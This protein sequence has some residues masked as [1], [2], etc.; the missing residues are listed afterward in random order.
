MGS[1][2]ELITRAVGLR[3][4]TPEILAASAQVSRRLVGADSTFAAIADTADNYPMLI[5]DGI[6]DARF[7]EITVRPGAGLGGQV[8]L[9][10]RP[11]SVADYARDPTIS[12]DFAHAVCDVEGLRG[13]ACVPVNGPDSHGSMA[14]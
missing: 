2:A 10:G 6:R 9:R 14:R 12:R 3:Q 4:T 8:L 7:R 1:P 11:H 5:T 13:M